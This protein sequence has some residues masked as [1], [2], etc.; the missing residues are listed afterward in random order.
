[1]SKHKIPN[2]ELSKIKGDDHWPE[3]LHVQ[4][5]SEYIKTRQY[6]FT[7]HKHSF[8]HLLYFTKGGGKQDIDFVSFPIK[9]G[10]IYFMIP[11]QV[12]NWKFVGETDGYVVD[13]MDEFFYSVLINTELLQKFSFFNGRCEDQVVQLPEA[14]QKEIVALFEKMINETKTRG[15]LAVIMI[16]TLLLQIFIIVSRNI[17]TNKIDRSPNPASIILRNFQRLVDENYIEKKLP[18]D[19]AALL[20]ITPNYLNVICKEVLGKSAG[21]IIRARTILEAKRLL[22]NG[23]TGI[24][25]IAYG[26]NFRDNSYFTKFFKKYTGKTPE[27]FRNKNNIR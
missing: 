19:Y 9:A 25:E 20:H 17:S 23:G 4:K 12:H 8:Y 21:E 13:F 11:G 18:K 27:E 22:A 3:D 16:R 26:L 14:V 5:F 7:P 15:N 6:L 24:S 1:M 2:Y 10:Q